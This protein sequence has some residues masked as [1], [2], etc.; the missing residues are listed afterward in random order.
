MIEFKIKYGKESI[1]TMNLQRETR[2][3][4]RIKYLTALILLV[5]IE[6]FIAI[7]IDDAFIRPYV[8]DMLVVMV[9]YC[10]VR[11][12]V[13]FKYRLMPLWIF[14]FAAFVEILQYFN[15]VGRLGLQDNRFWRIVM[16]TVFDWK[17]VAC[18][19]AGCIL[20]SVYEYRKFCRGCTKDGS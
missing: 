16:G 1:N 3:L 13:P 14:I 6:I 10:A 11:V 4:Y 18:Y 12:I 19:G 5:I 8:G 9:L 15:F 2:R 7:F 20:L 17:D